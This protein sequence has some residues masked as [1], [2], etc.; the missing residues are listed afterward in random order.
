MWEMIERLASDRLWIYTAISG[1]LFSA[2]FLFWFKD[3]KMAMWTVKKF[4]AFLE[5]L[6]VSWGLTWFQND[7]N[8][9][10]TKYPHITQKIDELENRLEKLEK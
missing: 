2:A 6:A 1:S 5:Y 8:A 3:T 4:D 7:P 9:W 10:R